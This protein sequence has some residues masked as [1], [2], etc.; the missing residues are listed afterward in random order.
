MKPAGC[1]DP[2]EALPW[3]AWRSPV[4]AAA[5][6]PLT[7]H[8][9]YPARAQHGTTKGAFPPYSTIIPQRPSSSINLDSYPFCRLFK[10]FLSFFTAVLEGFLSVLRPVLRDSYS[11]LMPF[12]KGFLSF[13]NACLRV[14]IL[15]KRLF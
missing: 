4:S 5:G 7:Q 6:V 9:R 8:T 13:F 15:F 12:L 10:G 2:S 14:T 3:I 1:S 11:F